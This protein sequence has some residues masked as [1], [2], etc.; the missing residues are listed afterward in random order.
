MGKAYHTRHDFQKRLD[1]FE[2]K[3]EELMKEYQMSEKAAS[4]SIN[5]QAPY[6][7]KKYELSRH[8]GG[9]KA[10]GLRKVLR[11]KEAVLSNRD[12]FGW[13]EEQSSRLRRFRRSVHKTA[14]QESRKEINETFP[15]T[16]S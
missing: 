14:R 16:E 7:S 2:K 15:E 8:P 6:H 11:E 4:L 5:R 10:S 3:R 9:T 12:R 13:A 1:E